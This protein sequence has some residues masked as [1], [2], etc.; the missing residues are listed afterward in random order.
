MKRDSDRSHKIEESNYNTQYHACLA[1]EK[2]ASYNFCENVTYRELRPSCTKF[3]N[4]TLPQ[5]KK[6]SKKKEPIN[7]MPTKSRKPIN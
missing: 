4:E 1:F 5:L 6:V 2:L 3:E 7:L